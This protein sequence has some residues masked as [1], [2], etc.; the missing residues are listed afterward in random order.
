MVLSWVIIFP[1]CVFS[2]FFFNYSLY[3]SFPFCVFSLFIFIII[4]YFYP[5]IL[6][7]VGERNEKRSNSSK[8]IGR[9]VKKGLIGT[10]SPQRR[11]QRK[12][13]KKER[14]GREKNGRKG[15]GKEWKKKGRKRMEGKAIQSAPV[16]S[17][18]GDKK[19]PPEIPALTIRL[20]PP[21]E[22]HRRRHPPLTS[23]RE[24]VGLLADWR[25]RSLVFFLF[26][27]FF[28]FNVDFSPLFSLSRF[29]F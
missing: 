14:K 20:V 18:S 12:K 15:D 10:R 9:Y 25:E 29:F 11:T 19:S 8:L 4:P 3:L 23:S 6:V 28:N 2:L 17:P 22:P 1:F 21:P 13:R 27:F 7:L 24:V 5:V 16:K 26:C